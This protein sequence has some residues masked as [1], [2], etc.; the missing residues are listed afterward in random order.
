MRSL[1]ESSTLRIVLWQWYRLDTS[2]ALSAW[3]EFELGPA[4]LVAAESL[5]NWTDERSEVV[6][7]GRHPSPDSMREIEH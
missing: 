7:S 3:D 4:R 1:Y 5:A 2:C 6:R